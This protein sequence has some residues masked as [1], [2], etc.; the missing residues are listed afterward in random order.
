MPQEAADA[1]RRGGINAVLHFSP[2]AASIFRKLADE[3]GLLAEAGRAL[4]VYISP[5]AAIDAF[6]KCKIAVRPN[7]AA[8]IAALGAAPPMR[9]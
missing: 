1:L 2:R 6:P 8:M 5:A 9:P 7:L 3:A 4:H